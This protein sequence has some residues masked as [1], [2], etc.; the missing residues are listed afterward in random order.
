MGK[1]LIQQRRVKGAPVYRSTSF[2]FKG[3]VKYFSLL[4]MV[5]DGFQKAEIKEIINCPGHSAP[6]MKLK[7]NKEDCLVVAPEGVRVGDTVNVGKPDVFKAGDLAYLRDIPIGYSVF[8]LESKHGDGGKFVRSSGTFAKIMAKSVSNDTVK[9]PSKK[10]KE[11]NIKCRATV[12]RIAGS[13]RTEKPLIKAGTVHH[14][15]RARGKL[16]PRTSG[17]AM[18][19]VDHPFGG[20]SSS[21][22]GR[23]TISPRNAPPGRKVG[24]L[25]PRRTGRRKR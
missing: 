15:M 18:N 7:L 6:L 3:K 12:G 13:G 17:V 19:S 24:K 16:Y 22:K 10:L 11:F 20:S 21:V 14:K 1:D 8:N 4:N 25:R 9:L 2:H 5:E 23:P